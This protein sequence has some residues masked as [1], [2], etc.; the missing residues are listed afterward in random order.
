MNPQ[1][2]DLLQ[3]Q[4]SLQ[5]LVSCD[6]RGVFALRLQEIVSKVNS[7]LQKL[8]SVE[9][10][11]SRRVEEGDLSEEEADEQQR[12]LLEE[13]LEIEEEPLP[14]SALRTVE[15]SVVDLNTLDWMIADENSTDT[16]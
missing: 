11:L 12:E 3:A 15:I 8:Q 10:D 6:L 4:E 1:N 13:T 9:E 2:L 14:Q 16:E 7:R 5:K